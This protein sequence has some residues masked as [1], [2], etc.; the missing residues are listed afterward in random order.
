[1]TKLSLSYPV[2]SAMMN[3]FPG[4]W[5]IQRWTEGHLFARG[6]CN[7]GQDFSSA[8]HIIIMMVDMLV[9]FQLNNKITLPGSFSLFLGPGSSTCCWCSPCPCR[10]PGAECWR[11]PALSQRCS[12]PWCWWAS[13][14]SAA[15]WSPRLWFSREAWE[16]FKLKNNF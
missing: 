8:T 9:C 1:M 4:G 2:S 14:C 3:L 12:P 15:S 10:S 16:T 11:R 13:V 6:E 7:F 5:N